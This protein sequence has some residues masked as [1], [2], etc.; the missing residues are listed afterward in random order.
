MTMDIP[1]ITRRLAAILAA[2]VAGY[3]RLMAANEEATLRTLDAYRR[4]I[5]DLISEHAGRIFGSAG[6]SVIAEFNSPVQSVRAAVAIQRALH[7]HNADLPDDRRM[8]FRIGV[9]LGDVMVDNDNLLGDGVNVAA[10]L[11]GVAD[12]GGICI[13]GAVHDQIEGKL[14][15]PLT[16][17]GQRTLK[18]ISRPVSV[19]AVD[20]RPEHPV[21]AGVLG[22][23]L[24][25]PDKPSIAVLPF[26]NMSGDPEQEY[27][28]D[29]ITEDIT[30]ALSRLRWFFVIAR[31]S[32]FTYKSKIVDVRL[33]AQELGV[34]YVLEGSVRKSGDRLRITAQL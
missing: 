32:S 15:F 13:S 23:D 7:R 24:A 30:T 2:D 4:T 34:R 12:P 6:D 1:L 33:I 28:A 16:S 21:V 8:E 27:F 26:S 11:E 22:G 10:R 5:S 14:N 19:Y 3:S 20:W 25:L 18:N 17:I 31:N 9:N 29:G